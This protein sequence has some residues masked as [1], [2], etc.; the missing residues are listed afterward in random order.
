MRRKFKLGD[1]IFTFDY[2]VVA[3]ILIIPFLNLSHFN[4]YKSKLNCILV[5]FVVTVLLRAFRFVETN[6]IPK[7]VYPL[8]GYLAVSMFF[9]NFPSSYEYLLVLLWGVLVSS[10]K[11]SEKTLNKIIKVLIILGMFFALTLIWQWA[12]PGSFYFVL[13][14]FV[15]DAQYQQAI[16]YTYG[17]DYTGFACES[18]WACLCISPAACILVAKLFFKETRR[19]NTIKNIIM[20]LIMLLAFYISGRRAIIL[21]FPVVVVAYIIYFLFKKRTAWS[22]LALMFI[23]LV[24]ILIVY[25]WGYEFAVG[26]LTKGNGHSIQLNNRGKYWGLAL[27][28]FRERP[29]TGLGMRS[30][31]IQYEIMSGRGMRF[32]GAHNCYLQYLAEMGIIGLFLFLLFIGFMIYKTLKNTL[33]CVRN[34]KDYPGFILMASLLMQCIFVCLGMSESVFFAPYSCSLYFAMLCLAENAGHIVHEEI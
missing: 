32:A 26:I 13:K 30:Y 10:L 22:I 20:L 25:F 12:A 31:D 15:S 34:G 3:L 28:M 7:I 11:F 4:V 24:G 6:P 14:R 1:I 29:L 16:E 18:I 27:R 8:L 23:L 21:V 33:Y 19:K 9:L 17:G 2:F 5:F